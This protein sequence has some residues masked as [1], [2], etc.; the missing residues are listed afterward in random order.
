MDAMSF[1][2]RNLTPRIGSEI[3]VNRAAL[4]RGDHRAEIR[5]LLEQRGVLVFRDVHLTDDEQRTFSKTI[6]DVLPQGH[7][8]VLKI[9]LDGGEKHSGYDYLYATICWHFDGT[10]DDIP[11]RAS[12]L[13][14]RKLS[15][16]GGNTEFANTYASYTDLSDDDKQKI[17]KLRVIHR[18]E[19]LQRVAHP[20]PSEQQLKLW[21]ALGEKSHPLVWAHKSGRK[22]LVL[23][24]T[25]TSVVGMEPT[26][27]RALIDRLQAWATQPQYIY[28]HTWRMGDLLIWDNTGV[29]HR[30]QPYPKDS[31]RLLHRCTLVGEEPLA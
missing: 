8:G 21:R 4:L 2:I 22:S 17:D 10:P 3:I 27:G 31:G 23:G 9:T 18:Q 12:I 15:E 7:E 30:V 26:E 24:L 13:S 29:I 14:P 16:V 6:G 5:E 19:T 25:A 1:Q 28:I 20:N 11:S